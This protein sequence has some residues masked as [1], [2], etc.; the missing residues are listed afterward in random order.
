MSDTLGRAFADA[1]GH[2]DAARLR[3]LLRADVDFR[4]M[5]PSDFWESDS[6]DEVIDEILLGKW[7][8]PSDVITQIVG[9]ETGTV[10]SWQ[11]VGYRFGLANAVGNHIVEQQAYIELDGDLIGSMRVMCSGFQTEE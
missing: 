9:V 4:A 1:L 8:Q 3:T 6:A 11:R 2:K 10:G 7:F 5:T